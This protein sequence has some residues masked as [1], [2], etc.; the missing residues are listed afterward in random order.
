MVWSGRDHC[1]QYHGGLAIS[2]FIAYLSSLD[3]T[4]YHRLLTIRAVQGSI[5]TLPGQFRC[6]IYR[7]AGGQ[8]GLVSFFMLT[9]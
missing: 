4:A 2:V 3:H 6:R 9:P 1:R 8:C 5:M 7:L